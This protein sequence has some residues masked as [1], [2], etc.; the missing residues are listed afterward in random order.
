[1]FDLGFQEILVIG[2]VALL[3]FGPH[4]LPELARTLGKTVGRLTKAMHDIKA[5]VQ[6][7]MH[8]NDPKL[9]D[10]L[11]TFKRDTYTP[12]TSYTQNIKEDDGSIEQHL[13]KPEPEKPQPD[14][15]QENTPPAKE[16]DA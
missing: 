13:I 14:S 11:P 8:E 1:M 16:K 6:R 3:V 2:V 4:R 10:S 12:P 15:S 9:K 5:E 7:E